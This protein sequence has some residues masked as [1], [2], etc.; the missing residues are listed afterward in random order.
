M[1]GTT[2]SGKRSA[3][4]NKEKYG[5]DFYTKIGQKGGRKSRTGGFFGN[6]ERALAAGQKA[7]AKLQGTCDICHKHFKNLPLHQYHNKKRG[8]DLHR[9]Q[10][11]D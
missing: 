11:D 10:L 3:A 5:A 7:R 6:R 1:G 8:H 2:E 9:R 4:T